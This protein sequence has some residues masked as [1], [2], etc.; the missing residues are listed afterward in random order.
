[1]SAV[2]STPIANRD[3]LANAVYLLLVATPF[4]RSDEATQKMSI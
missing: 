1:M 2:K 4:I 3:I